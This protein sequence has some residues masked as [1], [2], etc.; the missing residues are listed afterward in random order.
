[1]DRE[2]EF[3]FPA[4]NGYLSRQRAGE[5]GENAKMA[6]SWKQNHENAVDFNF[7]VNET[8]RFNLLINSKV[9]GKY[10]DADEEYLL[11]F[12]N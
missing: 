11:C 2:V 1:M 12:L 10:E 9:A 4:S 8:S 7:N 3:L 6:T 5:M